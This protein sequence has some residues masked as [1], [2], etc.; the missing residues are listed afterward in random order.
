[1]ETIT[2][3]A[4]RHPDGEIHTGLN[5]TDIRITAQ[6][7]GVWLEPFDKKNEGFVTS[8]NRFVNREEAGEIAFIAEQTKEKI[9]RLC[10]YHLTLK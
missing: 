10:S 9:D 5:H 6:K 2:R 4:I 1:M 3:A 7:H 8:N